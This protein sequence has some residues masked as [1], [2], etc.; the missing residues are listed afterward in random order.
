M[1]GCD[2][3]KCKRSYGRTGE[4]L[5]FPLRWHIFDAANRRSVSHGYPDEV[6][7]NLEDLCGVCDL[8]DVFQVRVA[9]R[10]VQGI[11][12]VDLVD[13]AGPCG[14]ALPSRHRQ[15]WLRLVGRTDAGGWLGLMVALPTLG[16]EAGE[17]RATGP[18]ATSPR[19]V[20]PVGAN[21]SAARVG[22]VPED[23][24]QKFDGGEDL[25]VGVEIVAVGSAIDNGVRAPWSTSSFWSE[26]GGRTMNCASAWRVSVEPAGMRI[27][28]STEKPLWVQ[29]TMF[30][31][32]KGC[33][34]HYEGSLI[35]VASQ[36]IGHLFVAPSC[37]HRE[38][39]F[40]WRTQSQY[41]FPG[42]LL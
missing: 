27:D 2:S 6:S 4:Y 28:A 14:A 41:G 9:T 21:K 38:P 16:R 10:A 24:D 23:L 18:R 17:V 1:I 20:Q 12:L 3:S 42:G 26:T 32:T 15:L 39:A 25:R 5:H 31:L 13:Q 7:Q 19:G 35:A 33:N 40:C 29:L 22:Q 8:G 37:V 34:P 11:R 30:E 36:Q